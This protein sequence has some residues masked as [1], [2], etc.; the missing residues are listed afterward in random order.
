MPMKQ[1]QKICNNCMYFSLLSSV[2]GTCQY[3][4]QFVQHSIMD[5]CGDGTWKSISNI[6][7][8]V[9]EYTLCDNELSYEEERSVE[10]RDKGN[11]FYIVVRQNIHN[12]LDI[13][14]VFKEEYA[15]RTFIIE[16]QRRDTN[17]EANM[18]IHMY[19]S[20]WV[21]SDEYYKTTEVLVNR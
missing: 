18:N 6:T 7:G 14:E 10:K 13:C 5:W 3:S 1:D 17:E 9:E 20:Y 2:D 4:S 11:K 15:A 16:E 8:R 21:Q 12:G 19:E